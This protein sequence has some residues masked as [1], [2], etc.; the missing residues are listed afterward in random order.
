MLFVGW[1]KDYPN[2]LSF[3][4]NR[5]KVKPEDVMTSSQS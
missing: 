4:P 1:Q 5:T 3:I 2:A